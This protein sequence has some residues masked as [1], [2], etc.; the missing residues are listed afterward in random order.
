M[1]QL[2]SISANTLYQSKFLPIFEEASSRIK[3]IILTAFLTMTPKNIMLV[4][5]IAI[6]KSVE[7][8]IPDLINKQAYIN[9]L[10]M[11]SQQWIRMFYDKPKVKFIE[12]KQS[13]ESIAE[14][15][16]PNLN[17]PAKLTQYIDKNR[18]KL[19]LWAEAKGTPYITNYDKEIESRMKLLA[20]NPVLT[21]EEGKK[22]ISL[23]QKAELDVRYEHQKEMLYKLIEEG[24]EYVYASSHPNCS[25]RC[26]TWQDELFSLNQRATSP[27]QNIK[28][29]R[30]NKSS[31][32]V[33][34]L[35]NKLVYSL[36]DVMNCVDEYG[37]QNNIICGFNCRH[38]LIPYTGQHAPKEYDKEDIKKQ[39]KIEGKIREL[40]RKIRALKQELLLMEKE[41]SL[42]KN[43]NLFIQIKMLKVQINKMAEYYKRFCESNGYAY[44]LYRIKVR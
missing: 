19:N 33:G 24:V 40:E 35:N 11:T 10:Y 16:L 3:V 42:T 14:G 4:S 37:Y 5:I 30:Y 20:E 18:T 31:F 17:T 29:H 1:A 39:R 28:N 41:Y 44:E 43:K 21:H 12:T 8:K 27:Q 36:T 38:R 9:G 15:R 34:K 13:V 22:S 26:E 2:K 25:K 7:K 23:W 6:I 32:L